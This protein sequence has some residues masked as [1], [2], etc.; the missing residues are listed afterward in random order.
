MCTMWVSPIGSFTFVAVQTSHQFMPGL[1]LPQLSLH[2]FCD[3]DSKSFFWRESI[4]PHKGMGGIPRFSGSQP[5]GRTQEIRNLFQLT[6][7]LDDVRHKEL[8]ES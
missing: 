8:E 3:Y 4:S 1:F 2:A 6:I 5:D 7:L